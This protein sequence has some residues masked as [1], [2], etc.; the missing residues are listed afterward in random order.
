MSEGPAHLVARQ[1]HDLIERQRLDALADHVLMRRFLAGDEPAFAALVRRHG[2]LVLGTCRRIL[3]HAQDAEDACQATFLILARKSGAIRATDSLAGWLHRVAVRAATR[4]RRRL[5]RKAT[6]PLPAEL[7][8]A[9]P[10]GDDLV[11]REVRQ[12]FDTEVGRLPDRLRLPLVLCCLQGKTRSEAAVELGWTEGAVRG[13]LERGRKV[14][15]SRFTRK[16]LTLPAALLPLLVEQVAPATTPTGIVTPSSAAARLADGVVRSMALARAKLMAGATAAVLV[17]GATIGL[18]VLG[19]AAAQPKSDGSPANPPVA[20]PATADDATRNL[21]T[22]VLRVSLAPAGEGKVDPKY[23]LYHVL[24]YVPNLRLEPPANGPDRKPIEGH[25]QITKDQAKKI[26]DALAAFDFFQN[27]SAFDDPQKAKLSLMNAR[28]WPHA[29]IAVRFQNGEDPARRERLLAWLP[30]ML[31]PLDAIRGCVDGEA[32][33]ALDQLFSQLAEYRQKWST[34]SLA[35]DLKR[36]QG[37][38]V[39]EVPDDRL[40]V[41]VGTNLMAKCV[42]DGKAISLK[43]QVQRNPLLDLETIQGTFELSAGTPRSMTIKG[44]RDTV[45]K[46]EPGTW[47]IPYEVGDGTLTIVLPRSNTAPSSGL[48]PKMDKGERLFAFKR[49]SAGRASDW[50][51]SSNSVQARIRTLKSRWAAGEI[52]TF[53]LDV[54]DTHAGISGKPWDWLAPRVAQLARVE[55]DGIWYYPQPMDFAK[56]ITH[57]LHLGQTVERWVAVRLTDG[58]W[59]DETVESKFPRRLEWKPGKHKVRIGFNFRSSEG[60][61][62]AEPVSGPLEI[63]VL[64]PPGK[65]VGIGSGWGDASD[66]LRARLRTTKTR[67][68]TGETIGI[69]FDVKSEATPAGRRWHAGKGGQYARVEVDGTWYV[70]KYQTWEKL[71]TYALGSG[72]E[73]SPWTMVNLS[74]DWVVEKSWPPRDLNLVPGKHKIRVEYGFL[75]DKIDPSAAP[76]GG[77]IEIE[78]VSDLDKKVGLDSPWGEASKGVSSRIRTPKG[79]F[80]KGEPLKLELDVRSAPADRLDPPV[81]QA[82]RNSNPARVEVAGVWYRWRE[83]EGAP[84]RM[85]K[86]AAG[87]QVDR[88]TVLDLSDDWLPE[89]YTGITTDQLNRRL[90]FPPGKYTIRVGFSFGNPPESPAPISGPL[91]IEITEPAPASK[92]PQS[93]WGEASDGIR[94]RIRTAKT[95]FRADEDIDIHYDVKTEATS[96]DRRWHAGGINPRVEVDGKWYSHRLRGFGAALKLDMTAGQEDSNWITLRL[97]SNWETEFPTCPLKLVPGK[98]KIRVEYSFLSDPTESPSAHTIS[99]PMEIEIVPDEKPG[100]TKSK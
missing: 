26:V 84:E 92:S 32:A 15:R 52:S 19:P 67:F 93:E 28:N 4:L 83:T 88:W 85:S 78:I 41:D 81:W 61:K 70:F 54:R 64:A 36:L 53:D 23:S 65:D 75:S 97:N 91:E 39:A 9:K 94:A 12:T 37:A 77:P 18:A 8:A 17:L 56:L 68:R 59:F 95:R 13:R 49:Q 29:G 74:A 58:E 71:V 66:G 46:Q 16:G 100:V 34:D 60:G 48:Q 33:K 20:P 82:A 76:V 80:A 62:T 96:A 55:V 69:Q 6:E 98:H 3:R 50:G 45:S 79:V 2:S 7:H 89:Y 47:A 35:E 25:A 10:T 1:V 21:E 14:L 44:V 99:G 51:E 42:I 5:V 24:L 27:D 30:P 73:V 90:T 40:R 43:P 38:W 31:P 87:Q 22:F 63:E 57:Q 72:V 11:W 86:L